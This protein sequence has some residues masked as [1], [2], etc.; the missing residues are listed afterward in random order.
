MAPSP[1]TPSTLI[2]APTP[3]AV[4]DFFSWATSASVSTRLE[5]RSTLSVGAGYAA[6]GA[7]FDEDQEILPRQYSEFATLGLATALSRTDTIA[8]ALSASNTITPLGAC[9][10]PEAGQTPPSNPRFCRQE[11]PVFQVLETYRHSLS[12]TETFTASAGVAITVER[13]STFQ[14]VA[15]IVPVASAAYSERF[16]HRGQG[17]FTLT[18]STAPSVDLRTGLATDRIAGAMIVTDQVDSSVQL[19]ASAGVTQSVPIPHPDPYPLTALTSGVGARIRIN[20]NV[21]AGLGLDAYWQHQPVADPR[22]S[23]SL[24]S[25]AGY[26]SVTARTDP[27]H[28]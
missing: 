7:L 13:T 10:P 3:Q 5:R 12:A 9:A 28:F 24:L 18:V 8:T 1:T 19:S 15:V 6:G 21:D 11:V 26:A 14:Q 27:L 2:S 23:E 4:I 17:S 22:V 25:V 16:G 20:R